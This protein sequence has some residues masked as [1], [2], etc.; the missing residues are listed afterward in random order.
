M[1]H[2]HEN[3]EDCCISCNEDEEVW[4]VHVHDNDCS[5]FNPVSGVQESLEAAGALRLA[6][7]PM[8]RER[9]ITDRTNIV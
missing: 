9:E 8:L 2:H 1:G 7:A 3:V 4:F 5:C 6:C